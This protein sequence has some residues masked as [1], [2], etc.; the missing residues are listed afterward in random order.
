MASVL[1]QG[2]LEGI[3]RSVQHPDKTPY[4]MP[5]ITR[6]PVMHETPSREPYEPCKAPGKV[7]HIIPS[8]ATRAQ[9]SDVTIDRHEREARA[10]L[11][12][13][14]AP[15]SCGVHF[16]RRKAKR[17]KKKKKKKKTPI[18]TVETD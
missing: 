2:R 9:P 14:R 4:G 13:K 5:L 3:P 8:S 6:R 11:E 7:T 16:P 17:R 10:F 15:T 1:E 18:G 12:T